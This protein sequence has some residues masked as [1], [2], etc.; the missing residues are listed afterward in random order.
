MQE[1]D[2]DAWIAA[3]EASRGL[4]D[5][6]MPLRDADWTAAAAWERTWEMSGHPHRCNLLGI[7]D[8]GRVAAWINLNEILY[9]VSDTA[10][11]GWS[12]S[13]PFA[14]RGIATEAVGALLDV[15][16]LAPPAG[17]GLHRVSCGIMPENA[18]SLRVAEKCGFRRE[19]YAPKLVR[20]NGEWR[21][22]VLFA[23][24]AEEHTITST[25]G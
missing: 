5:A 6:W 15:A 22:H 21:D 9:S 8:D 18:R 19:G 11:A 7:A 23:R 4:H 3:I 14:G 24:L 25:P 2:R 17:L 12:V 16:F 20:I 13:A 1:G 10:T